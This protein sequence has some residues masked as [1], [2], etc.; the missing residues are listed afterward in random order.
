M[1][2][3]YT[4]QVILFRIEIANAAAYSNLLR[5]FKVNMTEYSKELKIDI[6]AAGKCQGSAC[7]RRVCDTF[8][9][10]VADGNAGYDIPGQ[11]IQLGIRLIVLIEETADK[12][13]GTVQVGT[14]TD[15]RIEYVAVLKLVN[16][17]GTEGRTE[18]RREA[19][20]FPPIMEY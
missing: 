1:S 13:D 16:T 14:E 20:W 17:V 11:N 19:E 4:F 2:Q 7:Q 6:L 5:Y 10:A 12:V 15:F 18:S 9:P 8:V 3:I